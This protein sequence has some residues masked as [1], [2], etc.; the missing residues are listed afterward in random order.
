MMKFKTGRVTTAKKSDMV[1]HGAMSTP[2]NYMELFA[3]VWA[4]S[5]P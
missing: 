4:A 3:R 5:L 2:A 1:P